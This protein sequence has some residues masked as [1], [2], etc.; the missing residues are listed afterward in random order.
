MFKFPFS[1]FKAGIRIGGAPSDE[2]HPDPFKWKIWS[3][4]RFRLRPC[5]FRDQANDLNGA[6]RLNS[7]M[8]FRAD[9]WNDWNP[10]AN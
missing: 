3:R 8:G 6:K 1:M 2:A 9:F 4:R 10:L 5:S 7:S